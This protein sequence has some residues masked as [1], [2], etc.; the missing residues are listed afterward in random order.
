[1]ASEFLF[2]TPRWVRVRK[3]ETSYP[4]HILEFLIGVIESEQGFPGLGLLINDG[5]QNGCHN[6]CDSTGLWKQIQG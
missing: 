6:C 3:Q 2:C 4:L 5:N 1:M